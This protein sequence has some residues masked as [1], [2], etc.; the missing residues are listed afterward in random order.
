VSKEIIKMYKKNYIYFA[1][2]VAP[3]GIIE[4]Y[5]KDRAPQIINYEYDILEKNN[6]H[7][8]DSLFEAN[9]ENRIT[10]KNFWEEGDLL[11]QKRYWSS[12]KKIF[13][14]FKR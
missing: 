11:S 9:E 6:L 7:L 8:I 14:T 13:I 1:S 10:I 4:Q 12:S 5:K 2:V 3:I